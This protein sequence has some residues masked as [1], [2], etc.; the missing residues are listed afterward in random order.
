MYGQ[1]PKRCKVLSHLIVFASYLALTW[2]CTYLVAQP[3]QKTEP[4]QKAE[5]PQEAEAPQKAEPTQSGSS[6]P[7]DQRPNFLIL[8]AD[9]WG[10]YASSYAAIDSDPLQSIVRTPNIDRIAQRG[11]I[12]RQAFVSAPSCTPCRSALL[13][14]QHFWR[15]GQGAILQGAVWDPAIPS[16]PLLLDQAGYH[17]GETFKVWSPGTPG[18]AP[19]GAGK[20]AY[21]KSGRKFNDFSENVTAA[22]QKG[23]PIEQAK[24][25]LLEGIR[26]N[27]TEFLDAR[28]E[29]K[30][31]CYWFGP[32]NTHRQ[33]VA[34]SGTKLWGFNPDD[35]VGKLPPFL[36]DV[37]T[38]R[39]DLADYFGEIAAWDAAVG[40]LL[41]ELENRQLTDSTYVIIS[42]DHGPPGFPH[43]K[44]NLYAYGTSVCLLIAGP[45]VPPGRS[46]DD[47]V[48]L[49]DVAPTIL[50]SA[51]IDIPNTMTGRSLRS[52]LLSDASGRIDPTRDA[53]F[54]G[55][56]RH[57][58]NARADFAPYPQRALR[59]DEYLYIINF[60]PDRWPLGDPY[61]LNESTPP[62]YDRM[63][64][65]TRATLPDEDAGPTKAWLV[66]HRNDPQWKPLFEHA[67]G[68]RPREELYD[69]KSDPHQMNN[70]AA[71]EPYQSVRQALETRLLDELKRTGD[72]RVADQGSYFETP[73]LAGPLP[74]NNAATRNGQPRNAQPRNAPSKPKTP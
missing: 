62:S 26:A 74:Q 10:R 46:I 32:T 66:E 21:E 25:E 53:V 19:Y 2:N 73:P 43:G 69:L 56:E 22:V 33:W 47:L 60:R 70:L 52:L 40:R 31:F 64:E 39:Q 37:P 50:E 72:P 68:K 38:V 27:F 28:K 48:S 30:P 7:V 67:Y 11:A 4:P 12:F 61:G 57:V 44:C 13:S 23:E 35:F 42:G 49:T 45:A 17:I 71:E 1:L 29:D 16:F 15:T 24:E 6:K 51:G 55:R 3:L 9:D 58:E 20:F 34:Q 41:D 8:F 59:T 14:G 18:D 36:P 63:R 54:F 65:N 5:P